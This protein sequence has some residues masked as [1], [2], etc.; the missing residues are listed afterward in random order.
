M[1]AGKSSE[2]VAPNGTAPVVFE[3]IEPVRCLDQ[4]RP[5]SDYCIGDTHLVARCA[6]TYFLL[7]SRL[8][9]RLCNCGLVRGTVGGQSFSQR[10]EVL[11]AGIV[12]VSQ[13]DLMLS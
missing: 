3:M 2:D 12:E 8:E 11:C 5:L 4:G 6:K 1:I 13:A 9:L 7:E 10:V